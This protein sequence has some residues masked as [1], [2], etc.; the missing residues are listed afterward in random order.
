M[1]LTSDYKKNSEHRKL[2]CDNEYGFSVLSIPKDKD[3]AEYDVNDFIEL[4]DDWGKNQP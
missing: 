3:L 4:L 1:L 2:I